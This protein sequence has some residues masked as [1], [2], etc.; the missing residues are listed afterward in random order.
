MKLTLPYPPSINHYYRHVGAKVLISKAGRVYREHVALECIA[1]GAKRIDGR[2]R[3]L[4]Q[5]HASDR[6]R[7]DLDNT[8]KSLLDALQH[9]G[10]YDDDGNIDSLHI[11]RGEVDPANPRVLVVIGETEEVP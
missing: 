7:R 11:E 9:A 1:Q 3:V 4:V 2:L 5:T 8:L 6:K 10:V